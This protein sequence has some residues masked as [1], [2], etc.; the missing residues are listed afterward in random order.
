[1]K[2]TK[3]IKILIVDDEKDLVEMVAF[4]LERK[5]YL[6]QKAYNGMEAW[7]KIELDPPDLLILDLMMPHLDGWELCRLIRRSQKKALQEMGILMLTAKAMPDDRVYGLELGADDYLTKPFSVNE[8]ILRVKKIAE[9]KR[10]VSQL[11]EEVKSLQD[12]IQTQETHLRRISHDLKSPLISIGFVAKRMLRKEQKE[13]TLEAFQKIF[14]NSLYLTQW[15]DE[16]L[17]H[18]SLNAPMRQELVQEMD[19][20]SLLQKAI[21]LLKENALKKNIEI[22]FNPPK[23]LLNLPGQESL[24]F[25]VL[26]NLLSNAIKY[27]PRGGRVE[28]SLNAYLNQRGTGVFEISFKDNGIGIDEDDLTKIFQPFYRGKNIPSIE[29]KG[30]GL[31]FAKEVIEAH[32][33]KILVQSEPGRGSLFSILIP[34]KKRTQDLVQKPLPKTPPLS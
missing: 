21:N 32:G 15:I 16:T 9:K 25:R 31:S 27:T 12:S 28:I 26:V 22:V 14:E 6:I 18:P 29:G 8:L 7:E 1:M 11:Q 2:V 19:I 20:A 3:D 33:G 24:M 5:G 10:T 23:N 30:I 17:N 4:N 34:I 13:E